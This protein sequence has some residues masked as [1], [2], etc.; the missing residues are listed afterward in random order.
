MSHADRESELMDEID[1]LSA[2]EAAPLDD[3]FAELDRAMTLIARHHDAIARVSAADP[4]RMFVSATIDGRGFD[5]GKTFEDPESVRQLVLANERAG[6]AAALLDLAGFA[7]ELL[8]GLGAGELAA[9][10]INGIFNGPAAPVQDHDPGQD[11][12]AGLL[13]PPGA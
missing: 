13:P 5:L 4:D 8:A 2:H 12:A 6:L 11:P 9:E 1:E 7:V 10:R 3:R